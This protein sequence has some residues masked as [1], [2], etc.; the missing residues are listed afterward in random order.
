[1]WIGLLAGALLGTLGACAGK[2]KGSRNPEACMSSCEQER[3]SY[4]PNA[5]GNDEYLACL[6]ACGDR[7]S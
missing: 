7:C 4:D 3:C 6:E 1:M 2:G 5:V